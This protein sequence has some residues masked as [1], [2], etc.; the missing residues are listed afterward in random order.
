MIQEDKNE[1]ASPRGRIPLPLTSY[2]IR[3]VPVFIRV[4]PP[5]NPVPNISSGKCRGPK[6]VIVQGHFV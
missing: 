1:I 5:A 6:A 4:T 2:R 3:L